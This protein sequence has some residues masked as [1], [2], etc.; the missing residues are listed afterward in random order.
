VG[1]QH[2]ERCLLLAGTTRLILV[3]ATGRDDWLSGVVKQ[4][5]EIC[6]FDTPLPHWARGLSF[7][8]PRSWSGT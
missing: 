4:S 2:V 6:A 3:L 8:S 7:C 1:R 5:R